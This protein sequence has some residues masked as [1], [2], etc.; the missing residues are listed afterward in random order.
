MKSNYLKVLFLIL[1]L[2][3]ITNLSFAKTWGLGAVIG[4]PTGLSTNYFINDNR[5][6]H[7]TLAYDLNSDNDLRLTSHYTL[8][9]N[10][11]NFE[12]LNLGWF[13]G[14]GAQISLENHDHNNHHHDHKDVEFGPSGT[15]GLFHE[16]TKTPLEFFLKGNLTVNVISHT[17]AD[18]DGMLGLHYNF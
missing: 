17:N 11:L 6:I 7:T 3:S 8:R 16:F 14:M 4:D 1:P 15:I 12:K 18:L 9:V 5:T 13:Y 2:Q 10:N